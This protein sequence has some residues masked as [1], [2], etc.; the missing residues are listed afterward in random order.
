MA[1]HK[2]AIK[3]NRQN[4]VRRARNSQARAAIRTSVKKARTAI[5][6]NDKSAAELTKQSQTQLAKAAGKG[7]M[8]KKTASR[9]ASRLAKRLKASSK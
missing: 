3:R 4:I 6:A 9:L 7:L 5:S 8:N 1:T 2:S